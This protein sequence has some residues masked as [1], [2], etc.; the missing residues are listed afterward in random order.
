MSKI[1]PV[2][3]NPLAI[4]GPSGSG[5]TFLA[6]CLVEHY[7]FRLVLSTMTRQPRAGE[8][9]MVDNEFVTDNEFRTIEQNGD[10]FMV[11]RFFGTQ[12]G[13]RRSFVNQ[14]QA[15][16]HIPVA[17]VFTPIVDQFFAANPEAIGIFLAPSSVDLLHQRM[18]RRGDLPEQIAKR[19]AGVQEEIES[20]ELNKNLF[21]TVFDI[22]DDNDI[23]KVVE[24]ITQAYHL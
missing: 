17:I 16:S 7:P 12:Y 4:C 1:L 18:R 11:N 24:A 6:N 8:K 13:Y 19:L 5:K 9:H 14:I 20:Y 22:N 21:D 23:Y 15:A 2:H 10:F 3:T